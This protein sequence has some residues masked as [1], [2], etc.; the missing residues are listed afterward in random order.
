MSTRTIA[1]IITEIETRFKDTTNRVVTEAEWVAYIAQAWDEMVAIAPDLPFLRTQ[2]QF[3]VTFLAGDNEI[4]LDG[5]L[6]PAPFRL[7]GVY[8]ATDASPMTPLPNDA[9]AWELFPPSTPRGAPTHFQFISRYGAPTL[10]VYPTPS[11]ATDVY[12]AY[13]EETESLH[14]ISTG[15]KPPIPDQYLALMMHGALARAY[16][17]DHQWD[18]ASVHHGHFARIAERMRIDMLLPNTPGYPGI[19]DTFGS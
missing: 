4:S 14:G 16:E 19:R 1:S 5:V 11:R 2:D 7:T 18:A 17:D 9:L 10:L 15:Y 13:I 8:N 3:N 6:A 12:I